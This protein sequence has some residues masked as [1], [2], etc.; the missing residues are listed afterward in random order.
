[1]IST[2]STKPLDYLAVWAFGLVVFLMVLPIEA[3]ILFAFL[4]TKQE[5]LAAVFAIGCLV[6]VLVPICASWRRQ[7][8][9]PDAWRG[10]GYLNSAIAILTLNLIMKC[11][12][13]T[14]AILRSGK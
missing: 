5:G 10:R 11:L 3:D 8:S 4:A 12:V 14:S 7:R 1:M 9:A 13:L 2:S 6:L